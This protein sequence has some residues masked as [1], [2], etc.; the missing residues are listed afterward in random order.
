MPL[1]T[2]NLPS[3]RL[4]NDFGEVDEAMNQGVE[5]PSE[6]VFSIEGIEKSELEK[7]A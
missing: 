1:G 5:K 4:K 3:E 2:H 7:I 6:L